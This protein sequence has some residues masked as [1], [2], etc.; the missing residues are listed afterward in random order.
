MPRPGPT[1]STTSVDSRSL[2]RPMT[3]RMFSSTR[4]CWPR[5]FFGA[6]V[7][8]VRK[9]PRRSHESPPR[10]PRSSRSRTSAST[11]SVCTTLA[12][13]FGAPRTDCGARYGL[14][15]STRIRSRGML[16]AASR[17]ARRVRVRRVAGERHVVAAIDGDRER[18]RATRS[19]GGSPCRGRARAHSPSRRRPRGCGSRRGG[20]AR[21]RARAARRGVGVAARLSHI[22]E[23]CRARSHRRRLPSGAKAAHG[24]RRG[25]LPLASPPDA[26]RFRAPRRH[27]RSHRRS[28]AQ[29]EQESIPVPIV[30]IRVTPALRALSTSAEG[31]ASHASRCACE[32]V[33]VQRRP[34]SAPA[35]RR[36]PARRRASRRGVS[37]P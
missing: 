15:V 5:D 3:P 19:S 14:S 20:R 7:T 10:V 11:R 28:R 36:L 32:S 9:R 33:T 30:T 31:S 18:G 29:R 6:T 22:D 2:R 23:R 8:A 1:S 27:P 24:A 4:K 16:A 35:H 25:G 26:G 12:G 21:R 17:S 34:P 37:A 13:S